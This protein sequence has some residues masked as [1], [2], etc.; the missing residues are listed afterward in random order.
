MK[1]R[2]FRIESHRKI[3]RDVYLLD[4]TGDT[5]EILVPGQFVNIH[6]E[7][8]YLPRPI[9]ICDYAEQSLRLIYKVVGKGTQRLS[10]YAAG[11]T[12][13]ILLPLGNGFNT[14]ACGRK[15]LLIGGGVG[16]PPLVN[17]A[18]KLLQEGKQVEVLLGF[19]SKA[20]VF[21]EDLFA[22]LGLSCHISTLDGSY[23]HQG[24]VTDVLPRLDYDYIYTCGPEPMLHALGKLDVDGQ[25]SFEARMACGFG[26]CM[27]CSCKTKYG[28]KRICKE[29]PVLHK[30]EILW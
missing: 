25:F 12:L 28:Y 15:N 18:K 14:S 3:A 26:A 5:S 2:D 4:L 23:G 9:S 16:V 10:E 7:G 29:G 22:L 30:E 8:Y 19:N 13:Q 21:A 24:L 1:L 20:D 6:I 17:L 11:D 27:G